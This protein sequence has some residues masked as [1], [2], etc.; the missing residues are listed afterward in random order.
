TSAR[1]WRSPS[2]AD[3]CAGLQHGRLAP[4]LMQLTVQDAFALAARHEAAGRAADARSVYDEIL[5]ALQEHPGALL[6]IAVQE[7]ATG[8][9]ERARERS[10]ERRVGKGRRSLGR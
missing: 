3:R 2:E 6:K 8:A 5:S 10:E 7:L 4:A 1:C 9:H